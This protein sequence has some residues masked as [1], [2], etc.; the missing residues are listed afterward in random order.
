MVLFWS[1]SVTA[2]A[3]PVWWRSV[4]SLCS[5]GGHHGLSGSARPAPGRQSRS[6]LSQWL[7][8]EVEM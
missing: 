1:G 6:A 2:L 3:W 8:E 7:G 5:T 4:K